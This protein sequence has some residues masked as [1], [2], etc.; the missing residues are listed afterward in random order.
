MKIKSNNMTTDNTIQKPQ[1][2][3]TAIKLFVVSIVLGIVNAIINA[4]NNFKVYSDGMLLFFSIFGVGLMLFFVYQMNTGKSWARRIF[5]LLFI[6]GSIIAPF[7]FIR[8][9][10]S[11]PVVG[12]ISVIITIIQIVALILIYRKDSDEWFEQT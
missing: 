3:S 10:K 6:L 11:N 7:S 2:V 5:L 1:N 8:L 9:F 12:V 4:A